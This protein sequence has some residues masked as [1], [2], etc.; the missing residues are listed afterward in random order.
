MVDRKTR[1]YPSA[2]KTMVPVFDYDGSPFFR[3][4]RSLVARFS[5]APILFLGFSP[6]WMLLV[7]ISPVLIFDG[8]LPGSHLGS[9]QFLEGFLLVCVFGI[10]FFL[11]SFNAIGPLGSTSVFFR[12]PIDGISPIVVPDFNLM[13]FLASAL[14][15]TAMPIKHLNRKVSFAFP[16]LFC[17]KI[18]LHNP[19]IIME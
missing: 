18:D 7:I 11:T 8:S 17:H 5:G 19:I 10:P 2:S 9:G 16:A 15:I 14:Q 1:E 12:A 3:C 6:L 4:I 13:A